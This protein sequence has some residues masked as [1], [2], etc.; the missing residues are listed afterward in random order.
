VVLAVLI[1]AGLAILGT[2]LGYVLGGVAGGALLYVIMMEMVAP[3]LNRTIVD[4]TP[5]A[6]FFLA[7]LLFGAVVGGY[8]YGRA[9]AAT[10]LVSRQ[11]PRL[12]TRAV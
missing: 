3:N 7:H 8:V 1:R 5:R 11:A 6:P 12:R 4:F 9:T 2:P 10:R